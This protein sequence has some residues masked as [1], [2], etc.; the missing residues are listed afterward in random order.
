MVVEENPTRRPPADA[1]ECL[2]V[3]IE[4]ACDTTRACVTRAV[5]KACRS[6]ARQGAFDEATLATVV[7]FEAKHGICQALARHVDEMS[8]GRFVGCY[9]DDWL[10]VYEAVASE[11][12]TPEPELPEFRISLLP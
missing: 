6:A 12:E 9:W 1:L 11:D 4:P 5:A 7:G 8:E 10:A 3:Q 2:H